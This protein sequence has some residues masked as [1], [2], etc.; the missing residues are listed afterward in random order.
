MN[1]YGAQGEYYYD[2]LIKT[3]IQLA[4]HIDS[5]YPFTLNEL[6]FDLGID[7]NGNVWMYEVNT[8]PQLK[9]ADEERAL[10]IIGYAKLISNLIMEIR[11]D[12]KS[13]GTDFKITIN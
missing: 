3:A 6:G 8:L 4:E 9:G 12:G 2:L 11:K 10:H 7:T 13:Q 5:L 1:Q